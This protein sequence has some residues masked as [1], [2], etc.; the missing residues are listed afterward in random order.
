MANHPKGLGRRLSSKVLLTSRL[1]ES[2]EDGDDCEP[3]RP[4]GPRH[5]AFAPG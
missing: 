2:A 5:L 4:R 3:E 1:S